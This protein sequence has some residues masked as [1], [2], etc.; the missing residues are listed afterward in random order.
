MRKVILVAVVVV[1]LGGV[2]AFIPVGGDSG[3]EAGSTTPGP[4]MDLSQYSDEPTGQ[5]LR[6]LF[7]HHSVGGTL[8]AD[9]G[10]EGTGPYAPQC[11]WD[12]HP[13]GGGLRSLLTGAGYEVHEAS[14]GSRV[15]ESTDLFDWLPKFSDHMDEVLRVDVQDTSL[16]DDLR[17]Q[18]VMFKSCFPNSDFVGEGEAPGDT[19]G[20]ELTVWNAR[21]TLTALLERFA[22]HPDVLFVYLTA[23]PLAPPSPQPAWKWLA[24]TVLGRNVDPAE[25]RRA[26]ALARQFN[27]WVRSP[28]GWLR[29]YEHQNV[30]V[31]DLYDV[32]TDHGASNSLRY[33][34][35]GGTDSHPSAEG[36]RRAA[37]EILPFLNRAVRRAGLVGGAEADP[38]SS[39]SD[40]GPPQGDGGAPIAGDGA[41]VVE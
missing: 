39:E 20:P 15:G 38:A 35:G 34:T 12:T 14:Y 3:D 10:P 7:I 32:L 37:E 18:I 8:L 2:A 5:P 19:E 29:D 41:P 1:V 26:A 30:V 21:A 22:Q 13:N 31:F 24:K 33:P 27:N 11:I 4:A 6:L 28:N 23:P 16:P 25:R 36:T 40:A 17:N 9:Q